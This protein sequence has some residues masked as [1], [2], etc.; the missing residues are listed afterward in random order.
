MK[1]RSG[2]GLMTID[3][4]SDDEEARHSCEH[5]LSLCQALPSKLHSG[6][7]CA[8]LL[9]LQDEDS[10]D[11]MRK[12]PMCKGAWLLDSTARQQKK[13]KLSRNPKPELR[14]GLDGHV[15]CLLSA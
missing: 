14:I 9:R 12:S 7:C 15:F 10:A 1:I 3:D 5:N 4:D 6:I 11:G 13:G 8:D 2:F